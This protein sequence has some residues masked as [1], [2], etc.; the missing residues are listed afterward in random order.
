MKNYS[1]EVLSAIQNELDYNT[2]Y[3]LRQ[4]TSFDDMP[5]K[6]ASNNILISLLTN[7]AGKHETVLAFD[8]DAEIDGLCLGAWKTTSIGHFYCKDWKN[9]NKGIDSF[10]KY[11]ELE[12]KIKNIDLVIL[13]RLLDEDEMTEEEY[14]AYTDIS[15][16]NSNYA[17]MKIYINEFENYNTNSDFE[18][19]IYE[20]LEPV[21]VAPKRGRK[22]AKQQVE[23][24]EDDDDIEEGYFPSEP[25]F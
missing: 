14:D 9:A 21:E 2:E 8:K 20:D 16:E 17:V 11:S 7:E 4:F 23:S 1:D 5:K 15:I 6:I 24:E 3:A 25:L 22:P 19:D 13:L 18:D 12:I 10:S